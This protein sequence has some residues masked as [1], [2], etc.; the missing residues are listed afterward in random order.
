[1]KYPPIKVTRDK[2][3]PNRVNVEFAVPP[4]WVL[5]VWPTQECIEHPPR[6]M[7]LE[8]QVVTDLEIKSATLIDGLPVCYDVEADARAVAI[9]VMK[10]RP[11]LV[12]SVFGPGDEH[13]YIPIDTDFNSTIV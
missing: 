1:M 11:E 10:R 5:S 13:G 12:L 7:D 4:F 6:C 2:D 9:E 8:R 3:D